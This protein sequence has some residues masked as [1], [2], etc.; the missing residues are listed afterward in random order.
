MVLVVIHQDMAHPWAHH[1]VHHDSPKALLLWVK[2][3]TQSSSK[4]DFR[5]PIRVPSCHLLLMRWL[6]AYVKVFPTS[7]VYTVN[8]TITSL[9]ATSMYLIERFESEAAIRYCTFPFQ[10][11][12]MLLSSF[13]F[14][15]WK[16]EHATVAGAHVKV[17]M[18]GTFHQS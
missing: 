8:A 6:L 13:M 4:A 5:L 10:S 17:S 7:Y 12:V 9:L 1:M 2:I 11:I 16:S 14:S 18:T 15:L 3:H